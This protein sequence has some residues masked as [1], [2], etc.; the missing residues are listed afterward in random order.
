MAMKRMMR[1]N[2]INSGSKGK[3]EIRNRPDNNWQ[4]GRNDRM[5]DDRYEREFERGGMS[6]NE[7]PN[8]DRDREDRHKEKDWEKR[9]KWDDDDDEEGGGKYAGNFRHR[10]NPREHEA[11]EEVKFDEHKAK[12]WVQRMKN[13]DG[14][15]GEHFKAEQVE[16]LRTA[17]CPQCDKMEFWATMN[18]M[19]SDYCEVARKMNVDKPEFYACMAKAFLMDEDAGEDKLAKYMRYIPKK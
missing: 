3:E 13:G 16:Q 15:T 19:Y 6:R 14:S 11:D 1:M 2:I 8:G 5:Q 17:H 4:S 10:K 18:M 7:W 9:G 12:E